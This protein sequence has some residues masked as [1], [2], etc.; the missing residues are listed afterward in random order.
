MKPRL[1][2]ITSR[3][4]SCCLS[5]CYLGGKSES[6]RQEKFGKARELRNLVIAEFIVIVRA[7][8]PIKSDEVRPLLQVVREPA[9]FMQ[10]VNSWSEILP[11]QVLIKLPC[12]QIEC[13]AVHRSCGIRLSPRSIIRALQVSPLN[14]ARNAVR[15]LYSFRARVNGRDHSPLVAALAVKLPMALGN[16][17]MGGGPIPGSNAHQLVASVAT[18]NDCRIS[19]SRGGSSDIAHPNRVSQAVRT[20]INEGGSHE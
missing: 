15:S 17:C 20:R 19:T 8:I 9:S 12:R 18:E 5:N 6:V 1:L 14:R 10:G 11:S 2:R 13:F 16:P 4:S 7:L 3:L